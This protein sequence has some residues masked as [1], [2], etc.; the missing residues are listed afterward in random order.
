MTLHYRARRISEIIRRYTPVTLAGGS[1]GVLDND[2]GGMVGGALYEDPE[3]ARAR[4]RE[5]A[6]AEIEALYMPDEAT[7]LARVETIIGEQSDRKWAAK[8]IFEFFQG[9]K[10]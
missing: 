5:L 3:M 9:A 8:L 6:A 10:K 4:C 2:L 1:F 7:A